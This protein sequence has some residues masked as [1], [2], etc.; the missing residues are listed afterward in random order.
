MKTY[1]IILSCLLNAALL[2]GQSFVAHVS[3]DSVLIGNHI[4]V[5]FTIENLEG[6]FEAPDFEGMTILS[7]PN[8]SSSFTMINGS[9]SNHTKYSYT[10]KPQEQGQYY[11]KP[12]YLICE[13][14]TLETLPIEINVYPNPD[15]IITGQKPRTQSFFFDFNNPKPSPQPKPNNKEPSKPKRKLKKI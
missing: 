10:L 2:I 15:N 8:S 9:T 6:Q 12:A 4:D 3:L 1:S 7:G 14:K 13:D 5:T 11:I